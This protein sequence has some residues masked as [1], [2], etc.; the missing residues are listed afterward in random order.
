MEYSIRPSDDHAYIILT[1]TGE[2]TA[3][4]F[5]KCIVEAHTLGQEMGIHAYLVDATNA[6]NVDSAF[7]NYE[8]AYN[9]MKKTAGIDPLARVAGLINP[10]DHSHDFVETTTSNAGLLLKLFTDFTEATNYLKKQAP[11]GKA[12]EP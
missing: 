3:R 5:M 8:F 6:R 11:C 10:Q 12:Q 1:V 4:K 9:D 7:G 2:F